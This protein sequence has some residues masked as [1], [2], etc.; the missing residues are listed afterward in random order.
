[1]CLVVISVAA[2]AQ[3]QPVPP[4]D[5]VT[6][7]GNVNKPGVYPF[8]AHDTVR[9]VIGQAGGLQS[10]FD[11]NAYIYRTDNEGVSHTILV[12]LRQILE[13]R[14]AD[15]DLEPGDILNVPFP[16][17]ITPKKLPIIDGPIS[18]TD[19]RA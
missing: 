11:E 6:I 7:R 18:P 9:M 19:K 12:P 5:G 1:V 10:R 4:G 2:I 13:R 14:I 16:L 15:I 3:N 17:G 8:F